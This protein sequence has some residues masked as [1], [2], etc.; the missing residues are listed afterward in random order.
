MGFK[1]PKQSWIDFGS[2]GLRMKNWYWCKRCRRFHKPNSKVG[3]KHKSLDIR[4]KRTAKRY[5]W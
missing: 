5:R 4:I 2:R 3:F 1:R